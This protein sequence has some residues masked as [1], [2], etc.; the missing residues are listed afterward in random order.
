[1]YQQAV[2]S[3]RCYSKAAI[4]IGLIVFILYLI[5]NVMVFGAVANEIDKAHKQSMA[6]QPW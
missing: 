2:N 1:M 6:Q 4:I 5:L 3:T